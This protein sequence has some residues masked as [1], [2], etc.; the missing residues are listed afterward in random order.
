MCL[1]PGEDALV[2]QDER[3]AREVAN[4]RHI[5]QRDLKLAKQQKAKL[6]NMF[7]NMEAGDISELNVVLKA[8]VQGSVEA[9]PN[10]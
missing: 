2:V 6:E 8:D 1:L 10:H 5:K 7:A 9:I 3:K 4:K